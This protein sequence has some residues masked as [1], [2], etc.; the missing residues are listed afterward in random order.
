[1][2]IKE[3]HPY[4]IVAILFFGL[5]I[6]FASKSKNSNIELSKIKESVILEEYKK[7]QL[8][9]RTKLK[10][11]MA[12]IRLNSFHLL[13]SNNDSVS[14]H[15]LVDSPKLVLRICEKF[16]SPCI[17]DALNSLK[18]I[19]NAIGFNKML[20]IS[21]MKNAKLLNIFI[22]GN[23]VSSPCFAHHEGLEFEIEKLP[24]HNRAPYFFVLDQ[25]LRVSLP[26]FAN[27]NSD[28]NNIYIE[29]IINLFL[30]Q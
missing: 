3:N 28:L 2:S 14:I 21:D 1:M 8:K 22:D 27:E 20:I 29:R 4:L 17:D 12:D 11:Y 18:I 9:E 5:A 25:D 26:F 16:C 19:G 15:S 6:F 7:D 10:L 23:D 13:N 24:G 30:N